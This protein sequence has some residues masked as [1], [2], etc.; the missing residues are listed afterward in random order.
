MMTPQELF[1][2]LLGENYDMSRATLSY[3]LAVSNIK[4]YTRT[5]K[6][7]EEEFPNEVVA[8]AQFIYNK[9]TNGNI[10]S[11]TQGSRSITFTVDE[12]PVEIKSTLPRYIR[13]Y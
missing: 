12:I 9:N 2:S 4:N 13:V 1:L 8:L 7:V 11:M 6:D 3:R 5:N 10:K